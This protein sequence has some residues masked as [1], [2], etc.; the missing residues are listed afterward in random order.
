MNVKLIDNCC[1]CGLCKYKCPKEAIN[2][3]FNEAGFIIPVIDYKKCVDCGRCYKNCTQI[4]SF[5]SD[6]VFDQKY[7][8]FQTCDYDLYKKSSSGGVFGTVAKII[9][10]NKGIVYGCAKSNNNSLVLTRI[11]NID[12]IENL[13]GSKYG[14]S[15][16]NGTFY[17]IKNDL[18]KDKIVLVCALPCQIKAIKT[19]LQKD[20][21]NLLL[22][23]FVCHGVP[24]FLFFKDYLNYL[25]IS[26]H[27]KIKSV[28]FRAKK[29][30]PWGYEFELIG[31]KKS[32]HINFSKPYFLDRYFESFAKG[33]NLNR[34]CY[35]CRFK[36]F[37]RVSDI[38]IG[39]FWKIDK[40]F[41]EKFPFPAISMIMV[42]SK[43][44]EKILSDLK[45]NNHFIVEVDKKSIENANPEL[46][47]KKNTIVINQSFYEGYKDNPFMFISN[48]KIQK[49]PI[50]YIKYKIKKTFR[51]L[52][53]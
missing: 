40:S 49:H 24:S 53:K 14:Q 21:E 37:K 35:N 10:K 9:L 30:I 47:S 7:Y 52:F 45:C 6:K 2:Y 34:T 50:A 18:E 48:L 51:S 5:D 28:N 4:I 29:A 43:K 15:Y 31:Q 17:Q 44:G 11:N 8:A 26:N 19:F 36:S 39:D 3:S 16:E 22:M 32:K 25:E 23:D 13:Q 46:V 1:G 41:A 38:T 12:E 27:W 33:E 42:N 20:Y